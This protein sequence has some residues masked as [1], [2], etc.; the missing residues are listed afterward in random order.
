M[1][2]FGELQRRIGRKTIGKKLLDEVPVVLMAYDLIEGRAATS[3]SSRWPGGARS[4]RA[5]GG[6]RARRAVHSVAAGR[7]RTRGRSWPA[8]RATSREQNVEGLMLKR[9]TSPYRVG[10]VTRRLVEVEDRPATVDAVLI[11]AQRGSGKRAGLFTDYTFGVWDDG[12]LVPFAK[13]YSGL[14]DAEIRRSMPS[15]AG[16]RS[17]SSARSAR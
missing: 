1:L 2:P 14:T 3:A 6:G 9:K 10:R 12:K 15:S 13:A 17:R 8:E 5:G 7:G 4:W 16:T 11:Y